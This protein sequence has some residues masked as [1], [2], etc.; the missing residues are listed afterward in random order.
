MRSGAPVI[1]SQ[2]VIIA[3]A[4]SV[5]LAQ[6]LQSRDLA[7]VYMSEQN[8]GISHVCSGQRQDMR[9]NDE[10]HIYRGWV[11][12][13]GVFDNER[14]DYDKVGVRSRHEL[15]VISRSFRSKD[16]GGI[17]PHGTV[18]RSDIISPCSSWK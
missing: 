18:G 7:H 16:R 13:S 11:L 15:T 12:G 1:G 3:E 5:L 10:T 14:T 8:S 2:L 4:S 9:V 17:Y 6:E